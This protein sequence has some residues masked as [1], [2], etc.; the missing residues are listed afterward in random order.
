MDH[1]FYFYVES[2][3]PAWA[4]RVEEMITEVGLEMRGKLKGY[5]G[6]QNPFC[7]PSAASARLIVLD[8]STSVLSL[9]SSLRP[10][11][12]CAFV[13]Q[14]VGS[15]FENV[16]SVKAQGSSIGTRAIPCVESELPNLVVAILTGERVVLENVSP[17]FD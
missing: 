14:T 17:L 11:A 5:A 10:D 7:V 2:K 4:N 6:E 13:F 16:A 8:C 1:S 12:Y 9:P 3:N 15:K